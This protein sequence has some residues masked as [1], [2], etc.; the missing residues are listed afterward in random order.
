MA[1]STVEVLAERPRGPT[2]R[3]AGGSFRRASIWWSFWGARSC[4]GAAV[5]GRARRGA[6]RRVAGLGVGSGGASGGRGARICDGLPGLL[7]R[8]GV[9]E[10]GMALRARARHRARFGRGALLGGRGVVLADARVPR[11]LSFREA[12]VRVGRVIPRAVGGARAFELVGGRGGRLHGDPVSA[13]LLARAPAAKVL[14][15]SGGRLR[16]AAP[17]GRARG[18]A[19]LRAGARGVRARSP[20]LPSGAATPEGC[21]RRE[22]RRCW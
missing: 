5:G 9:E 10:A 8:G 18:V 7:R 4:R 11:S 22:G 15:V 19:A 17:C 1:A 14:V 6:R 20:R 13:R 16:G 2:R 12:A 3:A 21:S